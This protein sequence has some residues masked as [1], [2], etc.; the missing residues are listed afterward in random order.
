MLELILQLD[1]ETHCKLEDACFLQKMCWNADSW[2]LLQ[3]FKMWKFQMTLLK[4]MCM[5]KS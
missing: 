2:N 1:K 4:K 5:P 3:M